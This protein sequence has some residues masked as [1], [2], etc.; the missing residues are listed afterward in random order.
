MSFQKLDPEQA[1]EIASLFNTIENSERLAAKRAESGERDGCHWYGSA[2]R[3]AKRLRDVHG[4]T[5]VA[6]GPIEN[7]AKLEEEHFER[8]FAKIEPDADDNPSF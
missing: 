3:A 7:L 4:I 2:W 1:K 5:V 6:I 8:R